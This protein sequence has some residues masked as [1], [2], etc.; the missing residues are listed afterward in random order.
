MDDKVEKV[1]VR[2]RV[3]EYLE[4][5]P[6]VEQQFFGRMLKIKGF[7]GLRQG[8]NIEI[9]LP[10]IVNEVMQSTI[11]YKNLPSVPKVI[12][13]Y[14]K[15][16]I[17][18]DGRWRFHALAIED[19]K[20]NRNEDMWE[21]VFKK[22]AELRLLEDQG[23]CSLKSD[24]KKAEQK[25]DEEGTVIEEL[26]KSEKKESTQEIEK[27]KKQL[28]DTVEQN[29]E[30]KKNQKQEKSAHKQAIQELKNA[31]DVFKKENDNLKTEIIK[32]SQCI[33]E[34]KVKVDFVDKL[35]GSRRVLLI[36]IRSG[37]GRSFPIKYEGISLHE[38][39]EKHFPQG[40]F[41]DVY[42]PRDVADNLHWGMAL[43][44]IYGNYGDIAIH[45]LDESEIELFELEVEND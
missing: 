6:K 29:K 15:L 26:E 21:E 34:M 20:N 36:D 9:G 27:L 3:R 38:C 33:E 5:I 45:V 39:I 11:D 4:A 30:L 28:K 22:I 16:F 12:D 37:S 2:Q 44:Y 8:K 10:L 13:D 14:V 35:I 1:T 25:Q 18:F 40:D 31:R 23:K 43:D 17:D 32:L 7:G 24:T 41:T 19:I 42:V